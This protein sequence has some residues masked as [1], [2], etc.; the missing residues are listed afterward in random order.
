MSIFP[1]MVGPMVKDGEGIWIRTVSGLE[2][3]IYHYTFKVDGRTVVDPANPH[4]R[5]GLIRGQSS[6]LLVPATLEK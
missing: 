3:G 2:P 4:L 1:G 5:K 6:V